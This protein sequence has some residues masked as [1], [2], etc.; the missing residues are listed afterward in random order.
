MKAASLAFLGL[1]WRTTCCC[2]YGCGCGCD[3]CPGCS[4][5]LLLLLLLRLRLVGELEQSAAYDDDELADRHRLKWRSLLEIVMTVVVIII[6]PKAI[7]CCWPETSYFDSNG[8]HNNW[9]NK[10]NVPLPDTTFGI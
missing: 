7:S 10:Y 8:H 6:Q 1:G 4:L 2:G 9:D 5:L 3:C